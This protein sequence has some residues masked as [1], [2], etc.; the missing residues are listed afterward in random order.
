[1]SDSVMNLPKTPFIA[2][3]NPI[4]RAY[5]FDKLE[6]ESGWKKYLLNKWENYGV[7]PAIYIGRYVKVHKNLSI[8]PGT[9]ASP[10][11]Y[12]SENAPKNVM[13]WDY[14]T[15]EIGF[16]TVG[17]SDYISDGITRIFIINCDLNGKVFNKNIPANPENFEWA[18]VLRTKEDIWN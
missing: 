7:Y 18:Y 6:P 15:K 12:T 16:S 2:Q 4:F 3:Q 5:G 10:G 1:M 13:G 17:M 11:N 8:Q 9:Y 14:S